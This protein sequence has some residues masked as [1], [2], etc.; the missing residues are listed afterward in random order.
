MKKLK[1]LVIAPHPDDETIGCG[2]SLLKHRDSKDEI[3]CVTVTKLKPT[4]KKEKKLLKVKEKEIINVKKLY[5]FKYFINLNFQPTKLDSVPKKEL[6]SSL[7]KLFAKIKPEILY[8]PFF[9]DVH[10]DH[11]IVS[12][13]VLSSSKWFRSSSIK[14]INMYETL[15]ETNFNF[16][17]EEEFKP[18]FFIDITKYYEKKIKILK[19][20]KTEFKK[21]PFPR[22]EDAVESLAKLRGSQSGYK[23]AESFKIVF[24]KN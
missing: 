17:E 8:I 24:K 7:T 14:Q 15:S 3:S 22:S 18:N 5:K 13:S 2:G 16:S 19:C 21:H 11:Q 12:K 9:N 10:S 23:K 1:V 20:Y 4:N 6:V